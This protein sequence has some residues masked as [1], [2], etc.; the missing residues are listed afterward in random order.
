[1]SILQPQDPH[2]SCN[3]DPRLY[4]CKNCTVHLKSLFQYRNWQQ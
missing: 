1:M 2:D 3:I 4:R